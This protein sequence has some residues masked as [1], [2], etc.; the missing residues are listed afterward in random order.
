M[1]GSGEHGAE[2][3]CADQQAGGEEALQHDGLEFHGGSPLSFGG[4]AF[5]IYGARVMPNGYFRGKPRR[6]AVFWRS[7]QREE[8]SADGCPHCPDN[9][10]TVMRCVVW[11]IGRER[12]IVA[13]FMHRRWD[14]CAMVSG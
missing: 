14:G 5:E 6:S 12:L 13:F 1:D 10:R 11:P 8:V 2:G 4:E 9:I 7:V 3:G